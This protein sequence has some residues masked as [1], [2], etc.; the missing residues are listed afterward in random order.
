M[1]RLVLLFL[2]WSPAMHAQESV[3]NVHA[4][5]NRISRDG[6]SFFE[7]SAAGFVRVTPQ[8]AWRVLTDYERLPEFVPDLKS[9]IV[10]S[11]N[12]QE[13]ILEQTSEAGFL[14]LSQHVHMML[15]IREQPFS[16]IDVA[17]VSGDMKHYT[18]HWEL[19]ATTQ[20]GMRGTRIDFTGAMEPDFFV[21]PLVGKSIVQANVKKMVQAVVTEIE[22]RG[23]H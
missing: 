22:R 4:H 7:V 16:S 9:S 20:D 6:Q 21:P 14:F 11:R 23:A 18:A 1:R 12:A 15:R 5:A 19:E 10:K 3:H 17:L 13:I 8:H 2:L